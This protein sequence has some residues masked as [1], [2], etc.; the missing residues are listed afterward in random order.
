MIPCM[1]DEEWLSRV[2]RLIWLIEED[3]PSEKLKGILPR[4][5][6]A[7]EHFLRTGKR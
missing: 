2:D 4:L 5:K 6:R 1:S 3:P 7:R